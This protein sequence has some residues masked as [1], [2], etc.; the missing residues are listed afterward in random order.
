MMV[1]LTIFFVLF[2]VL[3]HRLATWRGRH[4]NVWAVWGLVF[5]PIPLLIL[6]V[7]P[8]KRAIA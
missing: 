1:G 2:A 3:C 6:L 8:S 7:M 4:A 5:G